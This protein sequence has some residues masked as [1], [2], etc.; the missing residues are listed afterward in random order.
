MDN[1]ILR[2]PEVKALTGLSRSTIWRLEKLGDFPQRIRCGLRGVGWLESEI[3]EYINGRER[4][5][6]GEIS[7]S[8]TK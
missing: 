1:R 2:F 4:I 6:L 8:N 3:A 7:Q 5:K